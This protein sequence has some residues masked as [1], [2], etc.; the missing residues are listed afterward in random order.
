MNVTHGCSWKNGNAFF[1]KANLLLPVD[2]FEKFPPKVHSVPC[3]SDKV[4]KITKI[5]FAFMFPPLQNKQ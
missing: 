5:L 3:E 4:A 2:V 1:Q